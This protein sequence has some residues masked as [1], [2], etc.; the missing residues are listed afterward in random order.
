MTRREFFSLTRKVGLTS[1][2]LLVPWDLLQ[3]LGATEDWYAEA[4]ALPQNYILRNGTAVVDTSL[5]SAGILSQSVSA[6]DAT[7]IVEEVTDEAFLWPKAPSKPTKVLRVRVVTPGTVTSQYDVNFTV[8]IVPEATHSL[9]VIAR[10]ENLGTVSQGIVLFLAQDTSLSRYY[11]WNNIQRGFPQP[12]TWTYQTLLISS[13]SQTSGT[14]P[15]A[16]NTHATIKLRFA[17]AAGET[18][19]YYV[20]SIRAN[21]LAQ[22]QIAVVFDDGYASDYTAAYPYMQARGLVGSCAI[23]LFGSSNMTVPQMQELQAA[24]WS[25]HNHTTNHADLATLTE[26]QIRTELETCRDYLRSNAIDSGPSVL[27]L[28]YGSRNA[29]VDQ[30]VAEYYHYIVQSDSGAYVGFPLWMGVPNTNLIDRVSMDVPTTAATTIGRINSA[31][32]RG[33][34][35]IIYGHNTKVGAASGNLELSTFQLV[36]DH[37]YRLHQAGAVGNPNLEQLFTRRANPRRMRIVT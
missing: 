34:S 37:L 24:G 1:A 9:S 26:A 29:L 36:M 21:T 19:S 28:P 8:S 3:R 2:A 22:P 7:W 30:V 32:A 25:M 16:A 35:M 4:S 10:G 20:G 31:V 18:P 33:N 6:G 23:D 15:T 14:P 17:V 5:G 12:Q 11:Q 13:P 27:V